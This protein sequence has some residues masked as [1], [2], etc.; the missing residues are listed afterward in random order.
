M[1]LGDGWGGSYRNL[2][3]KYSD[4]TKI[5]TTYIQWIQSSLHPPSLMQHL[6]RMPGFDHGGKLGD[7]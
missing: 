5:H 2:H 6:N 3:G 7:G 4:T 1:G